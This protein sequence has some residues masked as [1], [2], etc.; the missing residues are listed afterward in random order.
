ML[1]GQPPPCIHKKG[2]PLFG[3]PIRPAQRVHSCR[4]RH[5]HHQQ[6]RTPNRSRSAA[7]VSCS[8]S[9]SAACSGL[10]QQQQRDL[11]SSAP[12]WTKLL[13]AAAAFAAW[14]SIASLCRA[15]TPFLSL[16]LALG[17]SSEGKPHI[18]KA[19]R[20]AVSIHASAAWVIGSCSMLK[21]SRCSV[22]LFQ[23]A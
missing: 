12:L 15:A 13:G 19:C 10:Q 17:T 6:Q 9:S 18:A 22:M 2:Q 5:T 11:I 21:A 8:A 14:Y 23:Y 3:L 16:S 20:A 4:L 7:S 1:L